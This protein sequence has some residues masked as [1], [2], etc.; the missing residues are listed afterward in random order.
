MLV[1]IDRAGVKL[2]IVF[3]PVGGVPFPLIDLRAKEPSPYSQLRENRKSAHI[4][5]IRAEL[6]WATRLHSLSCT[7]VT[8]LWR[9]MV[10][11]AFIPSSSL[12]RT[13]EGTPR[14][15]EVMGATV[16]VAR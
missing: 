9:L 10:Q 14:M 5:C 2:K 3:R 4:S 6:S 12:S 11:G 13:S 1:P 16:T 8:G 7:T 15:V